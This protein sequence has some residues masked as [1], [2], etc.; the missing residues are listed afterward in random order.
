MGG[1]WI[2]KIMGS[3]NTDDYESRLYMDRML[4]NAGVYDRLEQMGV[5][6]GSIVVI[7][8]MEFEYIH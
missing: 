3:V 6:E 1:A 7:G 4:K 8:D 2:D 5:E